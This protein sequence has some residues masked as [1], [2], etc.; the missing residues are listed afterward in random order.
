MSRIG[1][2]QFEYERLCRVF[3]LAALRRANVN[4]PNVLKFLES[5]LAL[6]E[7]RISVSMSNPSDLTF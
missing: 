5:C 3:G 2:P 1:E 6:V 7:E 4:S